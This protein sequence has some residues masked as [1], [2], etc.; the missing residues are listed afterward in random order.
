MDNSTV[1]T[2]GTDTSEVVTWVLIGIV[3]CIC[4]YLWVGA[5]SDVK[6]GKINNNAQY[7]VSIGVL[8]T[9][10]GILYGLHNFDLSGASAIEDSIKEFLNGMKLSFITSVIGMFFSLLIKGKQGTIE[11]K[12]TEDQENNLDNLKYLKGLSGLPAEII[13]MAIQF[14]SSINSMVEVKN[15]LAA[16]TEVMQNSSNAGIAQSVEKLT[17]VIQEVKQTTQENNILTGRMA[18]VMENQNNQISSLRNVLV[19]SGKQQLEYLLSMKDNISSMKNVSCEMFNQTV[20]FHNAMNQSSDRQEQ[21]L[22]EN[23]QGLKDMRLSF[24]E[25]LKNMSENYSKA[26]IEAL[27]QSIRQLNVELQEQ[28]GGNF[29]KLNQAV[30]DLLDWQIHYK[31]TVESTQKQLNTFLDSVQAFESQVGETM[32]GLLS[33]MDGRIQAMDGSVS[34]LGDTLIS[35]DTSLEA[36]DQQM[37]TKLEAYLA[38]VENGLQEFSNNCNDILMTAASKIGSNLNQFEESWTENLDNSM[39][40]LQSVFT[41]FN[42]VLL[43]GVGQLNQKLC[44]TVEGYKDELLHNMGNSFGNLNNGLQTELEQVCARFQSEMGQSFNRLHGTLEK[45]MEGFFDTLEEDLEE[46]HDKFVHEAGDRMYDHTRELANRMSRSLESF[47]NSMN[48]TVQETMDALKNDFDEIGNKIAGAG[49]QQVRELGTALVAITNKMTENY[50]QLMDELARLHNIL[51]R[52]GE[53]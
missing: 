48:I 21:I 47:D 50:Q 7:S 36:F 28:L 30:T 51:M 1:V 9:F 4:C 25:F 49:E 18:E 3:F 37:R 20:G 40:E 26:F 5:R 52:N 29:Q 12:Q 32:P 27:T 34:R 11:D 8:G 14:N 35:V 43:A 15:S 33:Q 22:A 41:R 2:W 6:K 44:E 19:E 17:N 31:E 23:N 13:N 42:T 46:Q 10:V 39:T 16:L 38:G 45:G 53:R 24:D